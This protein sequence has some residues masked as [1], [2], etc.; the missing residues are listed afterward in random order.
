MEFVGWLS[1]WS[2]ITTTC[3]SSIIELL[4]KITG[5]ANGVPWIADLEGS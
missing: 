2:L 4:G 3:E 5:G 1:Q